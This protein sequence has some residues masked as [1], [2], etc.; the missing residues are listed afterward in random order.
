MARLACGA[1]A[2]GGRPVHFGG[3]SWPKLSR[4]GSWGPPRVPARCPKIGPGLG[5]LTPRLRA[6]LSPKAV[7]LRHHSEAPKEVG[8]PRKAPRCVP[9]SASFVGPAHL[10]GPDP[11]WVYKP[12]PSHLRPC[13]SGGGGPGRHQD[14]GRSAVP[15][16]RSLPPRWPRP[17]SSTRTWRPS[18]RRRRTPRGAP[19]WAPEA[20]GRR[21]CTAHG[22]Y[23]EAAE[24]LEQAISVRQ[25]LLGD[26][27]EAEHGLAACGAQ[28]FLR[29]IESYAGSQVQTLGTRS[30]CA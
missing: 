3:R 2:R 15:P 10:G 28:E 19:G 22:R 7:R 4:G 5:C 17:Y 14:R 12:R 21:F 16:G 20:P 18:T 1:E 6:P 9:G 24:Y 27:H 11:L 13:E 25:T 29:S 23:V 30:S 26:D 8:T